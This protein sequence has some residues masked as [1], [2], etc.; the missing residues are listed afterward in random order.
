MGFRL[1]LA[2]LATFATLPNPASGQDPN[3]GNRKAYEYGL[4][5]F[6]AGGISVPDERD[7]PSG[8]RTKTIRDHARKAYDVVYFMGDKLGYSK[9]KISADLDHAQ[10]MEMR[11]MMQSPAYF[12]QVKSDCAK[13]G[14]M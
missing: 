13:L 9:T 1:S 8:A 12:A 14:L 5:C 10:G 2:L 11:L 7:D 4:R 3:Y 6:V